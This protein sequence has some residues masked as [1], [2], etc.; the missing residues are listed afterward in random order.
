MSTITLEVPD[1]LLERIRAK[2]QDAGQ[3]SNVFAVAAIVAGLESFDD[4]DE[5]DE[6]MV[7]DMAMAI[8]ATKDDPGLP[9]EEAFD[10][11]RANF[12][13]RHRGSAA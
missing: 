1:E 4:A 2:A 9:L 3:D 13:A 6:E 5:I 8:E 10:E 12:R 11:I 7:A